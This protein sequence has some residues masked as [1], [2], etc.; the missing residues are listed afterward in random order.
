ML[1]TRANGTSFT[2]VRDYQKMKKAL[3]DALDKF[4][5]PELIE[6]L[7]DRDHLNLITDTV[8]DVLCCKMKPS[9]FQVF[10]NTLQR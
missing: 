2:A 8:L 5:I 9:D 4:S 3:F 6:I 7:Q 10:I 1:E